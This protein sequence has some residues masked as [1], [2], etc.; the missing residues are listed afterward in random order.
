MSSNH[1]PLPSRPPLDGPQQLSNS[2]HLV[3]EA[4]PCCCCSWDLSAPHPVHLLLWH[5]VLRKAQTTQLIHPTASNLPK[6]VDWRKLGKEPY[7]YSA[8]SGS[9][10]SAFCARVCLLAGARV[11]LQIPTVNPEAGNTAPDSCRVAVK[12][13]DTE[14]VA[15]TTAIARHWRK[16][17]GLLAWESL[18]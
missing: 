17:C 6:L 1:I 14:R 8:T 4:A 15:G 5:G 9:L 16:L 13:V 7:D 18:N 10:L 2:K 11:Y 12:E 3:L